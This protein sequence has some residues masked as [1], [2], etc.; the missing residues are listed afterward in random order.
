MIRIM[1]GWSHVGGSTTA[2]INLTNA[3]N[4][5]GY[6]TIFHGPHV[7]PKN[8]CNF[9][10][11]VLGQKFNVS[12]ED[13]LIA[14]FTKRFTSRPPVRGFF[15]SC[16]E[17]DIFPLLEMKYNIF[18]KIHFVSEHQKNY[19][20]IDH[21]HF[22]IPNILDDLKPSPKLDKKIGG[23]VGSVDK[24]KQVH[25]SIER[26]LKDGCDHVLIYGMI[27]DV[28]YW[29]KHVQDLVDGKRVIY[30]G[31]SENKQ[32]IYDSFTDLYFSSINE[33]AP[34][35][36]AEAKL[37][38][39]DIHTIDGKNYTNIEYENDKQKIVDKWV[40]ELGLDV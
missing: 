5:R 14:H 37:T 22:I 11:V 17:Q 10:Q 8:K 24:N 39:K 23:I 20:C 15:F 34:Y 6:E 25:V 30:K 29:K 16:H 18:D 1:S 38:G 32:E 21:P 35:V 31:Y 9:Q 3:L 4:D 19:H 40:E 36:L 13:I 7:Y 26:A 28:W 33:C 27:T 12:P 2:F